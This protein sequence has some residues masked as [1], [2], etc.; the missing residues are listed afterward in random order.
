[1]A[2]AVATNKLRSRLAQ[3]VFVHDPADATVAT[4]IGWVD[5]GVFENFMALVTVLAGAVVTFKIYASESSTGAGS[6]VVVKE[7]ATPTTADAVGDTLVLEC[8]AEELVALGTDLRYV[9]VELDMNGAADQAA[10]IY[11]RANPRHASGALT[12]DVIA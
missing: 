3:Y 9:S 2:S 4:K 6:P 12:A 8:S 5:L 1:M 10:V 7:H 11:T